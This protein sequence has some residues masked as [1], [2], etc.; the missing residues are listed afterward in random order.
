[1]PRSKLAVAGLVLVGFI[2]G[3]VAGGYAVFR[4]SKNLSSISKLVAVSYYAEYASVQ[5]QNASY[6]EAKEALLKYVE[7]VDQSRSSDTF[8]EKS[9]YLETG[10]AYG[11]LGLLE[12]RRGN[13]KAAQEYFREAQGRLQSAGWKDFSEAKVRDFLLNLDEREHKRTRQ[14]NI[15]AVDDRITPEQK[16]RQR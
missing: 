7:L 9:Y 3:A 15:V 16:K 11:R 1:M 2:S 12:E 10:L 13:R 4:F 14:A 8:V 6:S 5:Y